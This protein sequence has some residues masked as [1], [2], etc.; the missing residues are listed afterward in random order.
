MDGV[1]FD[2]SQTTLI[3]YPAGNAG[4]SYTIPNS[5][6]SIRNGAFEECTDLTRVTIPNSVTSIGSD[7]FQECTRLTSVTIPNSVINIG[8]EAFQACTSLTSVTIPASVTNI[9]DGAFESCY[10]LPAIVVDTLNPSYTSVDGVLFDKSLTT[11]VEY[12]GGKGG[13]YSIPNGVTSIGDSAFLDCRSLTN[14]TIGNSVTNIG[15]SAFSYCINLTSVSIPESV[16]SIGFEAFFLCDGMA[17][18]T[19]DASNPAYSSVD[20]VLFDKSQTTLIQY[21]AGNA[22]SSYTIP[23]SV[24]SI[25]NGAF[26]DCTY[27]T[28]VTIS[29]S[30][31]NIPGYAFMWDTLTSVTIPSSVTSIG[32]QAFALTSLTSLCFLGSAPTLGAAVFTDN[33]GAIVYY[34]PGNTGWGATF[35][36]L[37]TSL[38][39]PQAACGYTTT[40]GVVNITTYLGSGGAVSIPS[41]IDNLPVTGIGDYAFS[42]C[43]SLSS[44]TIPNSVTNIGDGAFSGCSSLTAITVDPLNSVYSSLDG[45][46]FDKIQTTLIFCPQAWAG[47]YKIPN[48]VT[49]IA[50]GAFYGRTS[51]SSVTIPNSVTNIGDGAFSGCTSLT[52]V[53]IGNSVTN[54]GDEAFSFCT[55][56]I[57]VYF[58]GNA[59]TLGW[60][61][62][63]DGLPVFPTWDPA[64]IYYLPGTTG[65]GTTFGGRPTALWFLPNPLI[66]N[67]GPSF[68]VQTNGFG[69]IISWA[70]NVPV[71]VE[72]ST[73]LATPTWYPLATNAL[74]SGSAYFSDPQWTNHSCRFYRLRSL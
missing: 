3:Q 25:R 13:F 14:V 2:K 67:I 31:T 69:F 18:I 37:A 21:P 45:V 23:N 7:A 54:I 56:L 63:S 16:T 6:T 65:W 24:T 66:L 38:W 41:T 59:P 52:N 12:P 51:L 55:S 60:G 70:T 48:G 32:D 17:S 40:N 11:L 27:L 62:F 73:N 36:G 8:S 22:G 20:G 34:V 35:A 15:D 42:G 39:N 9:G 29:N 30:V 64:T 53:T 49:S 68:G 26:E 58:Q 44:V 4:S 33:C 1:L 57:S 28:R 5:V 50:D 19:V 71:V 46:L 47:S 61:V 10:S 72:A 74:T 43:T